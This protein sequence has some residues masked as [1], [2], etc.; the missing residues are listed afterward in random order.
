VFIYA[1]ESGHSGRKIFDSP[2]I[3]RQGAILAVADVQPALEVVVRP[4]LASEG[5]DRIHAHKLSEEKVAA[6]GA[7]FLD[8]LDETGPWKFH[9]TE[10]EKPYIATA[11]FVDTI[12]DSGENLAVPWLW[13]NFEMFRHTICCLIDRVLT[14]RNKEGFWEAYLADNMAGIQAS[15]RNA[16]TYLDRLD[17]DRRLRQVVTEAFL[18]ALKHPEQFTLL[19]SMKR[20]SYQGHTPNMIGFSSLI[21]AIHGFVDEYRSEPIAFY[22]DQQQEFGQS[23]REMHELFGPLRY[24]D[25]DKGVLPDVERAKYDLAKFSMPSSK[26]MAALQA[27]DLLLWAY[28]RDP[29]TCALRDVRDRLRQRVD[30]FCIGRRMSELIVAAWRRRDRDRTL[31]DIE[32][33]QGKEAAK[34][35]EERRLAA[36]RDFEAAKHLGTRAPP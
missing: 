24:Q 33:A 29:V 22:H 16:K 5:V 18:F 7:K 9:I 19:A 10:I 30:P 31:S 27:T 6:I 14:Q 2:P 21:Q 26:Q 32:I 13:Y 28:Q 1:D 15:I 12:F 20:R 36:V 25:N 34:R 35:I 17:I 8:I 3:Y 11:K 4:S 23:M